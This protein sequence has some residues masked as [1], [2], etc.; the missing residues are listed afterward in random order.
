MQQRARVVSDSSNSMQ[1]RSAKKPLP[2]SPSKVSVAATRFPTRSTLVVPGFPEPVFLGSGIL[3]ARQT[4]I[5]VGIDPQRYASMTS[6]AVSG[7]ESVIA[8]SKVR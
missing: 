4:S 8:N 2:Q 7:M 1:G 3:K 5:A 6:P